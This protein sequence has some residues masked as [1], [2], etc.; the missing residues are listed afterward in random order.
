MITASLYIYKY[1]LRYYF[2]WCYFLLIFACGPEPEDHFSTPEVKNT[3]EEKTI[4]TPPN[5]NYDLKRYM[6][7][8][9]IDILHQLPKKSDFKN[10][11]E[12]ANLQEYKNSLYGE[13]QF[14]IAL[15]EKHRTYWKL[16]K[17]DSINYF[18]GPSTAEAYSDDTIE[19]IKYHT[20]IGTPFSDFFG[21]DYSIISNSAK[22][23]FS[24]GDLQVGP[25]FGTNLLNYNGIRP[26][27][28]V[29]ASFG[30]TASLDKNHDQ[31]NHTKAY[32]LQKMLACID[33]SAEDSH[34]FG[35]LNEVEIDQGLRAVSLNNQKC[36]SCH[37]QYSD[38]ANNVPIF[39]N[40]ANL[41]DWKKYT[42]ENFSGGKYAGHPFE[43]EKD[44]ANY[45]SN[46]PR[47]KACEIIN[48]IEDTLQVKFD[49]Y[50]HRKIYTHIFNEFSKNDS[51]VEAY[52]ELLRTKYYNKQLFT[53][54]SPT[55]EEPTEVDSARFL[56]RHHFRGI[57]SSMVMYPITFDSK[58]T[59]NNPVA[60]ETDQFKLS[61]DL[62]LKKS[63]ERQST[64]YLPD[65]NYI[66]SV[67]ELAD[68][69]SQKIVEDEFSAG[70]LGTAR[71]IFTDIPDGDGSSATQ[72]QIEKQIIA[73][74]FKFTS[75]DISSNSTKYVTLKSIFDTESQSDNSLAWKAVLF[76]ILCSPE[77]L[78]Y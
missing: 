56:T 5:E 71:K 37:A 55:V 39:A 78:T 68:V 12:K 17:R 35:D 58:Q 66:R 30:I 77:F 16:Y 52:R 25:S 6:R 74:W 21:L 59:I 54:N 28:G 32:A 70:T 24:L 19:T 26:A 20:S 27:F 4:I 53:P 73:M 11:P 57:V 9:S 69:V 50:D 10:Y 3:N 40:A 63:S 46:D 65:E 34:N 44:L 76:S 8:L 13:K 22:N 43:T 75:I 64:A 67:I 38:L 7:R 49:R 42:E 1:L 23:L 62:N 48:L 31:T 36:A 45:F 61:I 15:A 29:A 18:N 47:I 33:Y 14:H 60:I 2:F 51:I 41:I 72:S